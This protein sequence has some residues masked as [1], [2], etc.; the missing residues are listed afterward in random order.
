MLTSLVADA[1]HAN[2]QE[3]VLRQEGASIQ[4]TM[5]FSN[6]IAAGMTLGY[7]IFSGELVQA[8]E[9]CRENTIAYTLF[10]VRAAVIFLGVLCFVAIIKRFGAVTATAGTPPLAAARPLSTLLGST[11]S[12]A[13]LEGAHG[14][15]VTTVR[16][17]LTILLSF[18]LF[19][20]PVT[21]KHMAGAVTFGLALVVTFLEEKRKSNAK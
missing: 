1:V 8:M 4:E 3:R 2:T 6:L 7:C 16:K 14:R 11:R 10:I 18:V 19:P 5:I 17:I 9:Y 12:H 13:V 15:A 21:S 20:K